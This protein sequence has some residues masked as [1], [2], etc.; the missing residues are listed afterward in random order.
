MNLDSYLAGLRTRAVA[1]TTAAAS[2]ATFVR[3]RLPSLCTA[4]AREFGVRHIVV[5]GSLVAG[6]F[7]EHSDL[8]LAV[9]GLAP[10]AYWR[11]LDRACELAG[12]QVDLVCIESA[13]A[14]LR[15]VIEDEG[16][17]LLG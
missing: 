6:D 14:S 12:V 11:A 1:S 17:V 3:A 4:L 9:E 2:R 7:D 5:F 13:P 8:D 10:G 15:Q 16:E